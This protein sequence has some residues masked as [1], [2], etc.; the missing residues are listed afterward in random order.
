[1]LEFK[2]DMTSFKNCWK[3]QGE[4]RAD[5]IKSGVNLLNNGGTVLVTKI[6][7]EVDY[8]NE[9]AWIFASTAFMCLCKERN[10]FEPWKEMGELNWL[11][12]M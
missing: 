11:I 10:F 6:V 3:A 2:E 9:D 4:I 8:Q 12:L 5:Y 7:C 1:M